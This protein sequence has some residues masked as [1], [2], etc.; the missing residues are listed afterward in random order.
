MMG[1]GGHQEQMYNA[2]VHQ[3][4]PQRSARSDKSGQQQQLYAAP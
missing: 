3:G 4:N 2:P 1:H